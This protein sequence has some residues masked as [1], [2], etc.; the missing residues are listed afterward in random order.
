M[1][2]G[3]FGSI[4]LE[5]LFNGKIQKG[6]NGKHYICVEDL[7]GAPFNRSS[8]NG[9]TYVNIGVWVN[10]DVDEFNNI[11]SIS[12]HQTM[13]DREAGKKKQYI[14]N[15]KYSQAKGMAASPGVKNSV[16]DGQQAPPLDT[17]LPF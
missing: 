7:G 3:Y 2:Q 15:L 17:D 5:D 9:K 16:T 6:T 11:A 1:A 12:L 8:K 14:G 4:C 13:E 10:E